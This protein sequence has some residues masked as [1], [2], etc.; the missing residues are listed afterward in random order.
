MTD[1]KQ[2][3]ETVCRKSQTLAAKSI[4]T[5]ASVQNLRPSRYL[6]TCRIDADNFPPN[7][8]SLA[9]SFLVR[10][11]QAS[12]QSNNCGPSAS[13]VAAVDVALWPQFVLRALCS[14]Y[15]ISRCSVWRRRYNAERRRT[16]G[17]KRQARTPLTMVL[18]AW[19]LAACLSVSPCSASL[20]SGVPF[21][22][23]FGTPL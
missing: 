13:S 10:H 6:N 5:S 17:C 21:E 12:K 9:H 7:S 18:C 4:Q 3:Y 22:S 15:A 19:C 23:L 1:R 14:P 20:K 8:D 16:N 2:N 11:T